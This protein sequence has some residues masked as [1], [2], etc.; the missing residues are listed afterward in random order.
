MA[1]EAFVGRENARV[2][3]KLRT[4]TAR[5]KAKRAARSKSAALALSASVATSARS[6]SRAK[7]TSASSPSVRTALDDRPHRV[8]EGR[9]IRLDPLEEPGALDRAQP[10]QLEPTDCLRIA[11]RPQLAVSW[12]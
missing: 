9:E 2:V 3:R 4:G 7:R 1:R 12:G 10:G 8:E 6:N 5:D 11:H